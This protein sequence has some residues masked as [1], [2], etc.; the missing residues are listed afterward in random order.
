[1][2]VGGRMNQEWPLVLFRKSV[3][4]QQKFSHIVDLLGETHGLHCLDLGSDNGV[5][6]YMLRRKG[7]NWKSADLDEASVRAI[8]DVVQRDVFLIDGL[9]TAF[10][11][12]EFD[13]VVIVDFLEHIE[14]DSTFVRELYRIIRPGGEL[15]VN[16]P[17]A[18]PTILRKVRHALG[19]TDEKHGHVRPGY[20]VDS[21]T[22]LL[23]D[24][25]SILRYRSYSKFF[26]EVVDTLLTF[27]MDRTHTGR[28]S[29]RKGRVVVGD[30]VGRSRK[31]FGLYSMIYPIVWGFAK[32]DTLLF[33]CGGY[34]LACKAVSNK[35][36]SE[37]TG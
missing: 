12:N 4:K 18:R 19:Q 9:R 17:H 21:L 22:M 33:W 3:M 20:T 30:D 1:M 24:T 23:K 10:E 27:A 2:V 29:S 35:R 28:I 34:A 16:V 6:S 36:Q 11:D 8:R 32:L 26:T 25:F 37:G 13:R 31:A 15:I 5:I 14:T 7:G